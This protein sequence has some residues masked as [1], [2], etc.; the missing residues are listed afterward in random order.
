MVI[1]LIKWKLHF[2]DRKYLF[3]IKFTIM[4]IFKK[5]LRLGFNVILWF[6][7]EMKLTYFDLVMLNCPT[8]PPPPPAEAGGEGGEPK[9]EPA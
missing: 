7:L 4:I 5:V 6:I 9:D 8:S 3:P 2:P 1:R